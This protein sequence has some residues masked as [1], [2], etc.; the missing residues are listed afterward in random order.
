MRALLVGSGLLLL[1][2]ILGAAPQPLLYAPFDGAMQSSGSLGALTPHASMSGPFVPGARGQARRLGGKNT[3]IYYVDRDFLPPRGTCS[4]WVQP[5]DWTAAKADHF[6]F[7]T[8]FN[9]TGAEG[10]YV[11]VI[12]YKVYNETNVTLLV[13]STVDGEK[14]G[15]IKAPIEFWQKGQWHHLAFTWDPERYRLYVDGRPAGEAKTVVL[16][17]TGRWEIMVGTPYSSWAYI[18]NETTAIDEFTIWPDVLPAEEI[19]R[20]VDDVAPTLPPPPDE[21]QTAAGRPENLALLRNGAFVLASSFRDFTTNYADNLLDDN[22]DTYWRPHRPELPQWLEVRWPLPMRL[23]EVALQAETPGAITTCSV[24]AWEQGRQDWRKLDCSRIAGAQPAYTFPETQTQRLR[25]VIEHG[26][27]ARL[28]LSE[29]AVYGP[30]QPL[31][32]R[33]KPYWKASY[34]WYPEPDKIYKP[35]QPRYFRHVFAVADPKLVRSAILQLRSN[36]SYHA[37]LNGVAVASGSTTISPIAVADKLVPGRNVLAIEA[38]LH[39]NPGRWTWGELLYELAL[40]Y[41]DRTDTVPSGEKT[42]SSPAKQEGWLAAGFDDSQWQPAE[43]FFAPPGGPWGQIP[44]TATPVGEKAVLEGY[45]VRPERP[46]PGESV[47][48]EVTLRP[49][50][51]LRDDYFFVLS[52]GEQAAP[53]EWDNYEVVTMPL[54]PAPPSSQWPAGQPQTLAF[55]CD[56]PPW[57]PDGDVPLRLQAYGTK[58][59]MP[60]EVGDAS[61]KPFPRIGVLRL[62]RPNMTLAALP[63]PKLTTSPGAAALRVGSELIPPVMWSLQANSWERTQLYGDTGVRLYHVHSTPLKMDLLPETQAAIQRLLDQRA[64]NL[65]RV[66]PNGQI[67][68]DLELRPTTAWLEAHPQERLVT[69]MGTPGPVSFCSAAYFADV[70]QTLRNVVAFLKTRPYYSRI[71]GYMPMSCG[72]PDSAMGGV[73]PNL[74]QTDRSKVTVGDFNPQAV[75]AY[76]QWLKDKYGSVAKLR[77]AWGGTSRTAQITSFDDVQLDIR[78]LTREGAEGGVFRDPKDSVPTFD[79]FDFLSGI[80]GRFYTHIM[81]TIKQAAGPQAL[82]GAYYGYNVAHLRG[83]NMPGGMFNGNNYDLYER[84]SDPNWDFFAGPIPYESR[85]AGVPYKNYHATASLLLH[86]KLLMNE[87]DHR[88]FVAGAT[89]YGRLHSPRETEAMLKRDI[90][91]G[92]V[93]GSGYWFADWSSARGRDG[94]GWFTDPSIL[95]TVRETTAAGEKLLQQPKTGAQVALFIHGSTMGC[96]D[97]YRSEPIYENLV[98]RTVWDEMSRMGAPYDTYLLEDLADKRVRDGYKLYVLLN[99]YLLTSKER[100]LIEDLKR[101]GKTILCFYAPGYADREGTLADANITRLTGFRVTHTGPGEIMRYRLSNATHPITRGLPQDRDH[102]IAPYGY[103]LSVKLH[104]PAFGPVFHIQDAGEGA[105]AKYPDGTV[106]LAAQDFGKWKSVYC[107]VPFMAAEVLRGVCRYAGVHLYCEENV[108]LKADNRCVMVHNGYGAARELTVALPEER[109][110][111]DLC[112]GEVLS[113]RTRSVP[114]KLGEA[115]TRLLGL[116]APQ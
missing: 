24:Y 1:C 110:V 26:D 100:A 33:L 71:I 116:S 31:L 22:V 86:G 91:G 25:V 92:L 12:L 4:L 9:Y 78:E 27:A 42:L 83:Y 97:I 44:Y 62:A 8:S 79:Y 99:P 65:L 90:G 2:A 7:F 68:I 29:L 51:P 70:D 20:M 103:E 73:E 69:A 52:A 13:Q 50:G 43:R 54:M 37:W 82:V 101:D 72:A 106:A 113:P 93:E 58:N 95:Q 74:F 19:K 11:R 34:I 47:T 115:E 48:I 104:P 66:D 10:K 57:A 6:V 89:T 96:M 40:N 80:M 108:I 61:G 75:A 53:P 49:T 60:L 114:L 41:D 45:R 85:G 5:A 55:T 98:A 64:M 21:T 17:A 46:R 3:C 77:A 109:R 84:L 87:L 15:I 107:A 32:A 81:R 105:L 111:T 67:I 56:L 16:P 30:P 36:D 18:G 14:H 112:S 39:S 28:A 88:T 94:V 35:N 102:A 59:G 38:E 23:T 76:R 63:A